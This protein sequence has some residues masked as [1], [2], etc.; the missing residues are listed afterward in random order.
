MKRLL[1]AFLFFALLVAAWHWAFAAGIWSPVL[2][3]SPESVARYLWEVLRDGTLWDCSVVTM[4]RLLAG[5]V[6]GLLAGVTL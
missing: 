2:V 3:P 4:K 5:Y 6:L 1:S